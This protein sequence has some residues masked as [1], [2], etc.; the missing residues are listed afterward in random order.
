MYILEPGIRNWHWGTSIP[1]FGWPRYCW[2]GIRSNAK[3]YSASRDTS[4]RNVPPP[5]SVLGGIALPTP[6]ALSPSSLSRISA[7][8]R[9]AA[10]PEGARRLRR[11]RSGAVVP[12][13]KEG[14]GGSGREGR[15][16]RLRWRRKGAA[17]P[18]EKDGHGS[19]L[20]SPPRLHKQT[21][22]RRRSGRRP[23]PR[24]SACGRR[25]TSR[26]R[27]WRWRGGGARRTPPSSFAR[28]GCCCRA[29]P[30]VNLPPASIS[31]PC[32]CIQTRIGFVARIPILWLLWYWTKF[33]SNPL[34]IYIQTEPKTSFY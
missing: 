14:C 13:E 7:A 29:P 19:A 28:H 25:A 4:S 1:L 18:A 27:P 16:R 9:H 12:A 34:N 5:S 15:A 26:G 33:N 24:P 22:P 11:R 3:R 31:I 20:S 30:M 21:L 6:A 8:L 32:F 2:L 10:R 23:P 17:A